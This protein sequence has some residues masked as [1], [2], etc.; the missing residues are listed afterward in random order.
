MAFASDINFNV[1]A[2]TIILS[3]PDCRTELFRSPA[4]SCRQ[5]A[6]RKPVMMSIEPAATAFPSKALA[7]LAVALALPIVLAITVFPT[8]LYD[9]RELIAWGRQFAWVTPVHPPMMAWI[10]GAVD[11]LA[12]PSA[13]A[14]IL[15]GQLL[16]AVGLAYLYAIL[17]LVTAPGNAALFT[18]LFGASLYTVFAPLSFALNA[19]ILQLTPWPAIVF[20]GLRAG[21]TDRLT[22]WIALSVWSA[23]GVLTKY[24]TAVLF[25]GMA[26]AMLAVPTFRNVPRRP[27]FYLAVIIGLALVTPHAIAVAQNHGA[28]AWG[29]EHFDAASGFANE[30][31]RLYEYLLGYVICLMPGAL[32]VAIGFWRGSI[33]RR[34]LADTVSSDEHRF[35][36]VMNATMQIVLLA[37]LL[38]AGLDYV[39]RFDAPYA[40]M[41]V[42]A[43]APLVTWNEGCRA[44][45]ERQVSATIAAVY[46]TAGA[47]IIVLYLTFASHS[48]LQEPTPA[49]A[50][51][52]LADWHS[53]YPC[54]PAYVLGG[55]QAAYG[56][57]IE[58]GR[59]ITALSYR[60]IAGAPWFDPGAL[61]ARGAIVVD[62][63][64]GIGERMA[65]FL[66]GVAT[67]D[68]KS[69]ALPLRR[70]HKTKTFTYL[71]R[72]VAPQGC[73]PSS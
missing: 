46:L 19:D 42:P 44:W 24:N 67:S 51:A 1:E 65:R 40:M 13:A 50:R 15:T 16:L 73:H 21:R 32:V 47:I 52:I 71:Y 33:A 64:P 7:S 45:F 3:H 18:W 39:W 9:T 25:M 53:T 60:D 30:I 31:N 11:R 5:P 55:R 48:G 29:I 62:T 2:T 20:H 63:G 36:L 17:R 41:A 54:G 23:I 68:E 4:L 14:M 38:F 12:G 66:P 27:G 22:H 34:R 57:G 72:F 59:S 58:A 10:G 56:I 43:L 35:L 49:A 61:Q 70:T 26:M 28:I 69:I 8:P 6:L 37:L